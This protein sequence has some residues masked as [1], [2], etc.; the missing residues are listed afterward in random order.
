MD[1]LKARFAERSTHAGL[2][3]LA[4]AAASLLF[5]QYA[6]IIQMVAG[7]AGFGVA[8]LPTGGQPN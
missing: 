3:A 8:A 5:P 2:A 6:T 7:V 1:Y 4:L